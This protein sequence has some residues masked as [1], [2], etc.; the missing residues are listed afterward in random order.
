MSRIYLPG[1][2]K[3][4]DG[5]IYREPDNANTVLLIHSNDSEGSQTF[6]DSKN[7]RAITAYNHAKHSTLKRVF[8]ASSIYFDGND[9]IYLEDHADWDAGVGNF[10]IDFWVN[11]DDVAAD[12]AIC[13]HYDA[14][15]FCWGLKWS[16][17]ASQLLFKNING[18]TDSEIEFTWSPVANTWYHVALIRGWESDPNLW[19]GCVNGTKLDSGELGAGVNMAPTN[20]GQF[21]IG[22]YTVDEVPAVFDHCYLRGYIDEFRFIKGATAWTANFTPPK[23]M[24]I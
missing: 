7:A 11:F 15:D 6:V 13:G 17:S 10:S 8:G 23:G 18:V 14:A 22:F 24:Y 5:L 21:K 20:T 16:Y 19:A 1:R 3:E 4:M 9:Y 12:Q 2:S